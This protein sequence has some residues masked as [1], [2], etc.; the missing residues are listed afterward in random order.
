MIMCMIV[1]VMSGG[2]SLLPVMSLHPEAPSRDAAA[3]SPDKPALRE[4]D[5]KGGKG[6]LKNLLG[7]SEVAQCRNGHVAADAGEGVDVEEFHGQASGVG[8]IWKE[9][10]SRFAKAIT[11][12]SF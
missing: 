1:V 7:H 8:M 2:M 9:F 11:H 12:G 6:F 3:L 4:S 5:R 10:Q